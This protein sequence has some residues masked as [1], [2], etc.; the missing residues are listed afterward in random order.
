MQP[1]SADTLIQ[2]IQDIRSRL[3]SSP[4]SDSLTKALESEQ[5]SLRFL[6][7]QAALLESSEDRKNVKAIID[8]FA[9]DLQTRLDFLQEQVA[10]LG[11]TAAQTYRNQKKIKA[12]YGNNKLF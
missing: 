3:I 6:L 2:S 8:G 9:Q 12:Y 11:D 10:N 4:L 5:E 7:E 1:Q